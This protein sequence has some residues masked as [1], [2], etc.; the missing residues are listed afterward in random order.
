[1]SRK[2]RIAD[3]AEEAET[4]CQKN[5]PY[6][7]QHIARCHWDAADK[8]GRDNLRGGELL[9][10]GISRIAVTALIV[11]WVTVGLIQLPAE[12]LLLGRRFAIYRN[13]LCFLS[14]I[15][16]SFLTVHMLRWIG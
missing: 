10:G 12:M 15:P 4:K 16:V 5:A 11:N 13:A 2:R 14:A 8:S 6:V 3:A 9:T 1:M 7:C